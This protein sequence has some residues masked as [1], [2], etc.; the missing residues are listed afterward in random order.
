M[1]VVKSIPMPV[2]YGIF[3]YMGLVSLWT[4]QFW[5]RF[6]MLFMQPSLF[7][8]ALYTTGVCVGGGGWCWGWWWCWWCWWWWWWRWW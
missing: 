1:K 5:Q 8:P 2:L 7:P 6:T 3:L 4:N